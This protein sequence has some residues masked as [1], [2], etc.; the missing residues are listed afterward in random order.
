MRDNQKGGEF[1]LRPTRDGRVEKMKKKNSK[2]SWEGKARGIGKLGE[3][4]G[5][6]GKHRNKLV[7]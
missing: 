2:K 3:N 5:R 4:T 7:E 1:G 6:P